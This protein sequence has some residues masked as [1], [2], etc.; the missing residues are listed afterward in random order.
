[1]S[2]KRISIE[3]IV[4]L[5]L[6]VINLFLFY[7]NNMLNN[8]YETF[9]NENQIEKNRLFDSMLFSQEFFGK[10]LKSKIF[11]LKNVTNNN[12]E[13]IDLTYPL[14]I[15]FLSMNSCDLCTSYQI[16]LLNELNSFKLE[17]HNFNILAIGINS[18]RISLL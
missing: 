12:E 15:L 14:V 11:I 6:F 2:I 10:S 7:K 8:K 17:N 16:E 3:Y 13:K 4:I 9:I 1:M 5:S 18:S